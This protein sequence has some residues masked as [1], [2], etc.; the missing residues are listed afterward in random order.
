MAKGLS[1]PLAG[2]IVGI[3]GILV[4]FVL[5]ILIMITSDKITEEVF[6]TEEHNL[7]QMADVIADLID[8][9]IAAFVKEAELMSEHTE[10]VEHVID[11]DYKLLE[12]YVE[13]EFESSDFFD[14]L[15]VVDKSGTIT[16]NHPYDK[17]IGQNLDDHEEFRHMW[18]AVNDN[19]DEVFIDYEAYESEMSNEPVFIIGS[20]VVHNGAILG[21]FGMVVNVKKFYDYYLDDKVFGKT[22][23]AYIAG[24]DGRFVAHKKPEYNLRDVKNEVYM[25]E[26]LRRIN[27][28]I[29]N[30]LI[31]YEFEGQKKF[32]VYNELETVDW[33]V[34]M[35][36][37]EHDLDE[38]ADVLSKNMITIGVVSLIVLIILLIVVIVMFV[39]KP[40]NRVVV[41]LTDG[42]DNLESASQ[43]IAASSQQLSSGNS[44]LAASIEEITSS[45]EELQSVIELNTKN[46]NESELLMKE[47]NT[48]S[49]KVSQDMTSLSTALDEIGSNSEEIVNIVRVIEDIAFQ[50]NI[51]ALNAAV[52]A[53]RAG[54]A[55]SG[56]AVVA[57]QVKDLAQKSSESAKETAKLI[58]K[59]ID[60]ISK[61][62]EIGSSVKEAQDKTSEMSTNVTT[63]LNEVN[64]A[65]KEQMKGVNQITQAIT[66]TNSVV[67]QTASSAEE[68]AAASEELLGQ[69]EDL[70]GV[71]DSLNIVVKGK[72]TEKSKKKPITPKRT[73]EVT[74][75]N[76][77]EKAAESDS[78]FNPDDVIPM[79]DDFKEF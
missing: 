64:R 49:Q 15:F 34:A 60:S 5:A 17:M 46:I 44:E 30:G 65:S 31:P 72:V 42:A 3:A 32:L 79:G 48:N 40:I 61:G 67:Q 47:T 51:L 4:A 68:T 56:F 53:G 52:E 13:H 54:E 73:K 58:K 69:S 10:L 57:D 8:T 7:E 35:T 11:K 39:S 19:P 38:L 26:T 33:H 22:G 20:A 77:K 27:N 28:N 59:A 21:A 71:V 14:E 24:N 25:K 45:L 2:K 75:E 36:V 55:G 16:N 70:N 23:Y 66:Q 29:D 78:Q 18:E 50:T 1:I 63:L 43:Q 6:K 62:Q 74:A 76:S 12:E 9:E 37:Y 41:K